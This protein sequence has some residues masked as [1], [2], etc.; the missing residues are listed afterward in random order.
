MK[1][2]LASIILFVEDVD[3]LKSFYIDNLNL[4]LIEEIKPEWVLLKAGHCELGLHK[5]GAEYLKPNET[6]NKVDTNT[7]I[8][9]EI[10]EDIVAFRAKLIAKSTV[11]KEVKTWDNYNYWVCDGEDPE[12]NIF[13]LR[14]KK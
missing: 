11:L 5:I 1:A 3:R 2:T 9:F 7:K 14:M 12:G 13:Q 6:P 10:D 8:V 4:E